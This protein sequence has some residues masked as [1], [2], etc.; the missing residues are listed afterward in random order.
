MTRRDKAHGFRPRPVGEDADPRADGVDIAA[1]FRRDEDA[2]PRRAKAQRCHIRP[3]DGI[4]DGG[5]EGGGRTGKGADLVNRASAA[6][7]GVGQGRRAE[8]VVKERLAKRG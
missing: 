6:R 8:E 2:S 4:A 5:N 1:A 7:R 3:F